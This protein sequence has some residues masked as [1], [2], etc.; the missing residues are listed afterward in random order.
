M[1]D[2]YINNARSITNFCIHTSAYTFMGTHLGTPLG[3]PL[4]THLGTPLGTHL[5]TLLGTH[6]WLCL[7][8]LEA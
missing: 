6:F 7:I 3:T 8:K 5:G 2:E 1:L 4:G